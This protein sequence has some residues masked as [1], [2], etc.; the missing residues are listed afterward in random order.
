[1]KFSL[2]ILFVVGVIIVLY[3]GYGEA[4]VI[5]RFSNLQELLSKELSSAT[6][7]K[8]SRLDT[9]FFSMQKTWQIVRF[10]GIGVSLF[11]GFGIFLGI[12]EE[13]KK[14]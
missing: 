11:S 9:I 4:D 14:K 3:S 7:E 2:I 6:M 10:S 13:R 12:M 8:R 5:A 1:M